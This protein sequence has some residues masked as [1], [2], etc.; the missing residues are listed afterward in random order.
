MD[1]MK[2]FDELRAKAEAEAEASAPT[3]PK[4]VLFEKLKNSPGIAFY[5]IE[6]LKIVTDSMA[7]TKKDIARIPGVP[8]LSKLV[9]V[10]EG[11]VMDAG[12]ALWFT[13]E[14]SLKIIRQLLD[15]NCPEEVKE[16]FRT[17]IETLLS[18]PK[19]N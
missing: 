6:R 7:G 19:M 10:W 11:E 16:I 2:F 9:D 1:Y 17:S 3:M 4:E 5:N 14:A 15:P 12:L 18:N 13:R 8:S